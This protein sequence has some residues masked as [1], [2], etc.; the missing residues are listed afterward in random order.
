[1]DWTEWGTVFDR[2]NFLAIQIYL[3]FVAL[4][5][6]LTVILIVRHDWPLNAMLAPF[7]VMSVMAFVFG[8]MIAFSISAQ[9]S[10]DR[11]LFTPR[12]MDVF[13]RVVRIALAD[14]APVDFQNR[15]VTVAWGFRSDD[16]FAGGVER[17][18]A[19]VLEYWGWKRFPLRREFGWSF[20]ITG[21]DD[22]LAEAY[23]RLLDVGIRTRTWSFTE[24]LPVS[25]LVAAVAFSV[26]CVW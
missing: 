4:M 3:A 2:A 7:V 8:L 24:I 12:R 21:T 25:V 1:M 19:I 16:R 23:Q 5:A 9:A 11:K 6:V 20:A 10:A 13:Q 18:R 14:F 22:Q 17:E 15:R 26:W